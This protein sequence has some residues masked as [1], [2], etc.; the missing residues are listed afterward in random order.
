MT[1]AQ[2]KH[3]IADDEAKFQDWVH[4]TAVITSSPESSFE[5]II[6][7]LKRRGLPAEMAAT[8]LYSRTKRERAAGSIE[9]FIVDADDWKDY[10]KQSGL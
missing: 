7:C 2:A 3:L 1:L 4:A 9:A 8:A 10:I 6:E 5:D